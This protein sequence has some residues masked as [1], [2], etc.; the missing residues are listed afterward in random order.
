MLDS[1]TKHGLGKPSSDGWND[2]GRVD[3]SQSVSPKLESLA[4]SP[5]LK[6][7]FILVGIK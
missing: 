5:L 6:Q 4:V 2:V 3:P 7:M 1:W